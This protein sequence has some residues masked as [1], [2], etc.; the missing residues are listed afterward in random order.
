L[1]VVTRVRNTATLISVSGVSDTGGDVF[2]RA[3]SIATG[4]QDSEI[5][6]ASNAAAVQSVTV[7]VSQPSALAM[8]VLEISGA[9]SP[10]V[11]ASAAG[12]SMLA[13]TGSV[14]TIQSSIAVADIGWN[15][16]LD[17][18]VQGTGYGLLARQQ[19]TVAHVNTGEQAAYEILTGP[20]SE[21]YSATL[22]TSV[23]WAGVLVTFV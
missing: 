6:Y 14:A 11:A 18:N 21:S 5:W 3:A 2:K 20:S 15:R 17:V 8:T 9:S 10:D 22:S 4:Q 16:S 23:A 13:S 7:T 12:T 19:S 1:V